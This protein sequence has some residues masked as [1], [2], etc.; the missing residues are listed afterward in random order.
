MKSSRP[1]KG[2]FRILFGFTLL[3]VAAVLAVKHLLPG[4]QII[5]TFLGGYFIYLWGCAAMAKSK[6]YTGSQGILTG[7]I[8][9]IILVLIMPDRNAMSKA[10]RDADDREDAQGQAVLRAARRRPLTGPKK[11]LAGLFALFFFLLGAA[12]VTGYE[13]YNAKVLMPELNRLATAVSIS[14]DKLDPQND[15]KLVHVTGALAGAEKLSDPE[16]GVAVDALKLRRRVWMYQWEQGSRESKSSYGTEDGKGNTTTWLKTE[17]YTYTENWFENV[18]SSQSF[19]NSGHD[20]PTAMKIPVRAATAT[21]ITVGAF[22]VAPELSAQLDNFTTVPL[23]LTNLAALDVPLRTSAKQSGAELFFGANHDQPAIGDLKVRVE[24]A[25]PAD[26]SIIA[27]QKGNVLCPYEM[28][29][30]ASVALL[31]VG[32]YSV[33]EMAAQFAKTNFQQRMI[34]WVAGGILMLCGL[35]LMALARRR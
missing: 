30:A 14:A 1:H 5:Y 28:G 7:M 27:R 26:A 25:L 19:Y 18:I 9:P 35:G 11:V 22:T 6:G 17:T 34:V 2:L 32:N 31:R 16:F 4:L 29:G 10:Q 21:N 33:P 15:G 24:V 23:N 3:I 12:I 13:V 20:N 8:F